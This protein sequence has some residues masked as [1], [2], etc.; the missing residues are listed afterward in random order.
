METKRKQTTK[1]T[2]SAF[3]K[4]SAGKVVMDFALTR[5]SKTL[6]DL[7]GRISFREDYDYKSLRK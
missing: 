4:T 7:K 6:K 1:K 2:G 5:K 3:N